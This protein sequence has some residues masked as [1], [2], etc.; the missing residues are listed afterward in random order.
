MVLA[1]GCA[2]SPWSATGSATGSTNRPSRPE[3]GGPAVQ[4]VSHSPAAAIDATAASPA[5]SEAAALQ[6]VMAELQQLGA[7]DPDARERLMADMRRTDPAVWPDMLRVFR[8]SAAY[9]RR[10]GQGRETS[11]GVAG[12]AT[13]AGGNLPN[14]GRGPAPEMSGPRGQPQPR[15]PQPIAHLPRLPVTDDVA[16]A[17]EGPPPGNYPSAGQSGV[18]AVSHD[19]P[20]GGDWPA[21]LADAIESLRLEVQKLESKHLE[22]E[23]SPGGPSEAARTV[24]DTLASKQ[25]EL[26][27]LYL[28]AGR[29]EE[30]LR[31]IS[32]ESAAMQEFWTAQCHGLDTLLDVKRTPDTM[33]RA[34]QAKRML[35]DAVARLGETAPLVV[36]NLTFCTK[37]ESYGR[38]K[39][40]SRT[41]F[42]P[43]QELL[44]YAEIE[45]FTSQST[46]KGYHT[47]LR[48]SYQIFDARNQRVADHQFT[49]TEEHC[50]RPRRD[51][52]IGYHL[53]L[54]RRIYS[55]RH[56]LQLTVEDL[57]SQKV[58]Q[59]TIELTIKSVDD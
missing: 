11:A 24:R 59:S 33:V 23:R 19:R 49:T 13:A 16:L 22:L 55:G 39:E 57:K 37:I 21:Q 2:S 56:T 50:R 8:A 28:L 38:V 25:A 43:G 35:A 31:P 12:P 6:E 15:P 20:S 44:L 7:L 42:A 10:A 36:R 17:P 3:S 1:A 46:P 5:G 51:Y 58:T 29:R 48:S 30:A 18:V 27:I 26:R 47:A 45:N 53:R 41:E 40:F 9:R 34:R 4:G 14:G 54:P 52:F 32:A